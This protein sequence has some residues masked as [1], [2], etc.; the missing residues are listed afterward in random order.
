MFF[1]FDAALLLV[2]SGMGAAATLRALQ[3]IEQPVSRV[4]VAGFCGGLDERLEVG[5]LVQP[6]EVCD[7]QG[8]VW[9][10]A[11]GPRVG[12]PGRLV[13][14]DRPVLGV[15]ERHALQARSGAV[16]VDMEAA[17]AARFLSERGIAFA[18]LKAVSDDARH[19]LPP[20][21]AAALDGERVRTGRL[22]RAVLV[23]PLLVADLW[24]L[25]RC[26]RLA[27]RR[28]AE[29][30]HRLLAERQPWQT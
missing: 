10:I 6:D 26:S 16:A 7:E 17:T 20:D 8:N 21:L 27:A 19:G 29:G 1:R 9:P 14:L 3:G 2:Q 4:I 22:L 23:R 28:L 11:P 5:A 30:V 18:C 24:R 15:S 13:S 12:L 25:A